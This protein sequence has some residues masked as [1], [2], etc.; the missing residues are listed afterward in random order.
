MEALGGLAVAERDIHALRT[1]RVDSGPLRRL[2][3]REPA[4]R[5]VPPRSASGAPTSRHARLALPVRRKT[6]SV[7]LPSPCSLRSRGRQ[8]DTAQHRHSGPHASPTDCAAR[9]AALL[10][11]RTLL[12]RHERRDSARNRRDTNA[13]LSPTERTLVQSPTAQLPPYST[14]PTDVSEGSSPQTGHE[15]AGRIVTSSVERSAAS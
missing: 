10:I 5:V 2:H 8:D 9:C 6:H 3:E 13:P 14:S 7:C 15:G 1:A 11:P 12:S 4:S